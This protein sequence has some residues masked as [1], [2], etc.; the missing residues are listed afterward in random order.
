MVNIFSKI[1]RNNL[2]LATLVAFLILTLGIFLYWFCLGIQP[3]SKNSGDSI[4]F[5]IEKGKSASQIGESL[6]KKGLIKSPLVFKLYVQFFNKSKGIQTGKFEL[7]PSYSL[8]KIVEVIS[9]APQEVWVTIPE[10]LRREEVVDRYIKGLDKG[11]KEATLF[12]ENFLKESEGLEGYLFPDTYLIPKDIQ[13]SKVVLMMKNNFDKKISEIKSNYPFG[14]SLK[15]VVILAS[16]IEREAKTD[17][18]R[19]VIAGIL[20]NRLEKKW[21]LQVDA[22]VQYAVASLKM[23]NQGNQVDK[24]WE[25]LREGDLDIDSPYN[26]YKY[27]G[28]PPGPISNPGLKSLKAAANPLMSDYFFYIHADG[29]VYYARTFEEHNSNIRKYLRK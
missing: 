9:S 17:E 25:T 13:A 28:L 19:P 8:V 27:Q 20:Y 29:K 18:E 15:E 22:A 6:Y 23:K 10:G 14:Y 11:G 1:K 3:V 16:L 12:R 5:V 7:S 4:S 2:T 24:Y 26:T 21:P